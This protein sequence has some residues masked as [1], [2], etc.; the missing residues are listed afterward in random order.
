MSCRP[1]SLLPYC[2]AAFLLIMAGLAAPVAAADD[3][4]LR[5]AQGVAG[6]VDK[7][8]ADFAKGDIDNAKRALTEAYFQ[9]FEDSKLEAAIRRHVSAKRAA[10]IEKLFSTMRKAMTAKDAAQVKS[11]AQSIRDQITAEAKGLDAEKI[12]PGVFEVNQ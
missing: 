7:A 11:V 3:H 12:A 10:E 8:E 9:H 2:T 6:A 5:Q 4:W 1:P